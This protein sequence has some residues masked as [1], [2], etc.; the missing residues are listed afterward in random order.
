MPLTGITRVLS[1][2]ILI[3]GEALGNFS[4]WTKN[5]KETERTQFFFRAEEFIMLTFLHTQIRIL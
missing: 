1:K 3:A 4:K 5:K 2:T